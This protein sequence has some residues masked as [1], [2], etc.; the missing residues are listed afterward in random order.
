MAFDNTGAPYDPTAIVVD[1]TFSPAKYAAYSPVFV[2]TI[3]ALAWGVAFA[4]FAS[5]VVHTFRKCL[6]SF[7]P[8]GIRNSLGRFLIVWYRRDIAR[9]F[10]SSLRDEKDVHAR[11][12]SKYPE[13]PHWW[14]GIIGIF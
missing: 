5:V 6:L 3:L 10:N 12:M 2:S 11:L 8:F 14:Y 4:S 13:V 1:G 9:R 7:F